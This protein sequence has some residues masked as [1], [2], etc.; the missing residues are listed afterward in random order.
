MKEKQFVH[1]LSINSGF[2]EKEILD[3]KAI[4][5]SNEKTFYRRDCIGHIARK[6]AIKAWKDRLVFDGKRS[7]LELNDE[8]I[9]LIIADLE[10]DIDIKNAMI[11]NIK[12]DQFTKNDGIA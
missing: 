6:N 12:D 4:L 8:N 7:K 11:M 3:A 5:I 9:A 10:N 2:S 1:N